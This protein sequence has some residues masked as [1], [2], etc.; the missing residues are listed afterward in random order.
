MSDITAI[1]SGLG[2][3]VN[4][5]M[6]GDEIIMEIK[7]STVYADMVIE[8][9]VCTE[10]MGVMLGFSGLS[11][12]DVHVTD[13]PSLPYYNTMTNSAWGA[14]TQITNVKFIGFKGTN[15]CGEKSTAITL[16]PAGSDYIPM[17]HFNGCSFEDVNDAGFTYIFDPPPGWANIADCG[18]WPCTSPE[19]IVMKFD[20]TSFSGTTP[21][22][23]QSRFQI[24]SDYKDVSSKIDTCKKID[25][26]N[27]WHCQN[28]KI[29]MLL[30]ESLDGDKSERSV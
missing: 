4:G 17:A 12:K 27:A 28:E 26:M 25:V 3:L 19:N 1:D 16:N 15:A 11:G 20:Q 21:S 30:F 10:S 13:P 24:I 5:G 29:S 18:E 6:E 14:R 22:N 9:T 23:T 8:D 7:D 2:M